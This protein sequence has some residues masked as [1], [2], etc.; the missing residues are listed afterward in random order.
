MDASLLWRCVLVN[1]T[2]NGHFREDNDR[3]ETEENPRNE[4]DSIGNK[5]R[6]GWPSL[7]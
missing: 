7:D 5:L 4:A 2:L 3:W 6:H 1:A